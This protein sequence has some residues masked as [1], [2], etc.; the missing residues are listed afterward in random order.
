MSTNEGT[1]DAYPEQA[2]AIIGIGLRLP[3]ATNPGEFWKKLTEGVESIT[4]FTEEELL[5][6]GVPPEELRSPNYVRSRGIIE[7][8]DLFDASFFGFTPRDAELLDPQQ[9]IFL[10]CAWHALEDGGQIP[11]KTDARIAVYGGVGTNWHLGEVSRH[12]AAKKYA[13]PTS[14]VTSNDK[15]YVAT[16]VSYKLN[17]TGPSVNVQCACS[18]SLVATLLGVSSLNSYQCD[19]ALA[20]GATIQVPE[21]KGY[22]YQEGGMESPDG[23]CRPFDAN[24]QGT[25]FSRGAAV[26]L[27]KRLSD[28]LEDGDN[29]YAV[30]LDGA[31]NND[32]GEKVGFTATRATLFGAMWPRLFPCLHFVERSHTLTIPGVFF[33]PWLRVVLDPTT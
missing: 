18:T 6:S 5:G 15:D 24:A 1:G 12:P 9:R 19:L 3:G 10:E 2:V 11:G 22:L 32:G 27:L 25:V 29:I 28:A 16:R 26:V 21:R 31:I 23:H 30:I 13:N 8:A 4:T 14:V 20:G 33:S 17:L 7:G